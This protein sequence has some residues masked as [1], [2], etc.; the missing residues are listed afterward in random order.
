MRDASRRGFV[1]SAGVLA[2]AVTARVRAQILGRMPRIGVLAE[3][4]EP[5]PMLAAFLDGMRELGY[6]D[7]KTIV[8]EKRFGLGTVGKYPEMA[9]ELVGLGVD[10]LVVGGGVAARAARDATSAVPI[11]FTSVGDPVAAGLVASLSRPGGNATGL[12]NVV[13]DL[14]GKQLEL[15]KLAAPRIGRVAVL[16]NSLNSG[17]ALTVTR[18]AARSLGLEV[19]PLDVRH[20]GNLQ[21]VLTQ[22]VEWKA[23]AILALSDPVLGNALSPLAKFALTHRLPAIYSRDEFAQSGGLLAYGP[24]FAS[25]Y[26]R[27]ASYVDRILKGAKPG[28]LA[29]ERPT[30]FD[31]V[32]NLKTAKAIGLP[33]PKAILQRADRVIE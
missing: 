26:R 21:G 2:L 29:V 13:S 30:K 24:D 12:S 8:V 1:V 15:L 10:V 17:P 14:S 6:V 22:A 18:E 33:V 25:N 9:R 27:A 16:H 19:A 3:R 4:P 20:A 11:V 23:E 7:G 31:L 5:D 28:D 32:V